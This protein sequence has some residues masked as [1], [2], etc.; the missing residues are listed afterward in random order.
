MARRTE[1]RGTSERLLGSHQKSWLWG[2][3][4]VVETLR[5]GRWIPHE[6]RLS[7][8]LPES[9]LAVVQKLARSCSAPTELEA[10]NRLTQL[11]GSREHQ[12]YLAR[13][14]PFPYDDADE[15][16]ASLPECSL[17]LVLD[18]IQDPHNFGAMLRSA[19]VLGVDAIFI[20]TQNQVDVTSQVARSSAGA[21]NFVKLA[22]AASLLKLVRQL[23]SRGIAILGASE[24]AIRHPSEANF[25]RSTAI[26]IGNEGKGIN[27]AI[28]ME[29]DDLVQI[30]Q[31][32][33][34]NSLNAAVAAGIL[35]YEATRQRRDRP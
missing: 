15:V 12:G 16:I 34:I 13:M 14:P 5:A 17:S 27:T 32:G 10:P 7:N 23:K 1:K 24:K 30:P 8:E 25:H 29:C 35:L 9:E 31:S 4:V 3:N 26:V 18:E 11:S 22:R 20:G 21:V 28:A 19:E 2:R 33:R 6:V